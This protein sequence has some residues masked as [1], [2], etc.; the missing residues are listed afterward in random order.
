MH[1][2]ALTSLPVTS[3]KPR[4][5]DQTIARPLPLPPQ[6][7]RKKV[8]KLILQTGHTYIPKALFR[9]QGIICESLSNYGFFYC[10]VHIE[11][12]CQKHFPAGFR[13]ILIKPLSLRC[14]VITA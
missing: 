1:A 5:N 6:D 14:S 12:N 9:P 11:L 2:I 3:L 8:R 13:K 10:A 4:T 7:N